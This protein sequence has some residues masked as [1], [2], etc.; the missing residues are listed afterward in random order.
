MFVGHG[1]ALAGRVWL[2]GWLAGVLADAADGDAAVRGEPGG[3]GDLC[4]GVA[5][6]WVAAAFLASYLPSRRAATVDP[7]EALRAE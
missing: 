6:G 4:G 2:A 7:V 5:V 3:S 1:L